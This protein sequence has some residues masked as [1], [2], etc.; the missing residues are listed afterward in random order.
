[1]HFPPAGEKNGSGIT[2]VQPNTTLTS[3][4]IVGADRKFYRATTRLKGSALALSSPQVTAPVAM[5]YAWSNHPLPLL[6][7]REGLPNAPF[8]TDNWPGVTKERK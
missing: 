2:L 6:Y 1:M 8:R 4:A 3:F 7:N 5:R